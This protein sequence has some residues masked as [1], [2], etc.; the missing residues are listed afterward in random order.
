MKKRT[1]IN[2]EGKLPNR[3]ERK[4]NLRSLLYDEISESHHDDFLIPI[5]LAL[6][7]VLPNSLLA[8][9]RSSESH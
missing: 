5:L 3:R 8:D 7:S 6:A 2:G 4:C 9:R 1:L